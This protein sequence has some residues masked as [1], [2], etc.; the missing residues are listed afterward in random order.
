MDSV[1]EAKVKE[2]IEGLNKAKAKKADWSKIAAVA[3]AVKATDI[4]SSS[5]RPPQTSGVTSGV[6]AFASNKVVPS[7]GKPLCDKDKLA[8]LGTADTMAAA[9]WTDPEFEIW[10]V[11]Q[12][13]TFPAFRRADLLFELHDKSYW[14]D[15]NVMERLNR[16]Q[17]P[18]YMHDHYDAIPR[19]I[20][21]PLE[22]V[23]MYRR[24]QTTTITYML[25]WAYHSFLKIGKPL[26]VF[27][28]GVHMEHREEYTVQ[29]PCCEYWLGRMEGAGM[30]IFL[31]GGALLRSQGLYGYEGYNPLCMKFRQRLEGLSN[32]AGVREQERDEAEGKRRE[33][34]GAMK[35]VEYWLRLAQTGELNKVGV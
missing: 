28:A 8:I 16:W 29:R 27:L 6:G 13:V 20:K 30:D 21:F 3:A 25:A 14:G 22:D 33:Q 26:H 9:P 17:G 1:T 24:Y 5:T 31:A 32:G 2:H 10:G 4:F 18:L 19:S 7:N 15:K 34:L 35:E 11:A 23:L 12:V